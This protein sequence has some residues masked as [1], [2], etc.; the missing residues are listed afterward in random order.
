MHHGKSAM[1]MHTLHT[2]IPE[3]ENTQPVRQP[4]HKTSSG[5]AETGLLTP[6]ITTKEEQS[7]SGAAPEN[8]S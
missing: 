6:S 2:Q 5:K 4:L 3:Q 7:S 8:F 1:N